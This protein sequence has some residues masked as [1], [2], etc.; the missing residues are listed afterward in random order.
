MLHVIKDLE[1]LKINA[2]DGDIGFVYDFYFDDESWTTRYLVA[3]TGNW[4]TGRKILLSPH[5]IDKPDFE[6]KSIPVKLIRKQIEDGPGINHD[7]PVSRQHESKLSDYYGWPSYWMIE[8]VSHADVIQNKLKKDDVVEQDRKKRKGDPH[9]RS[10]R[11]VRSYTVEAIDGEVG[12]VDSFLIDD[13]NWNIKYLVID[14]RKWLSW[15]PGGKYHIISPQ[16]I[17]EIDWENSRIVIEYDKDTLENS[18]MYDPEQVIDIEFE[19]KLYDCYR[20]FIHRKYEF[21]T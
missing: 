10:I 5:A 17:K 18:P 14:T 4:L 12:Q 7:E 19:N 9:L 21:I 8:P 11:E 16:W 13:E 1:R 3:D 2:K 15:L 20:Q 6:N